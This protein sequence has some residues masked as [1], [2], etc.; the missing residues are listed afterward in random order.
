MQSKKGAR[1]HVIKYFILMYKQGSWTKFVLAFLDFLVLDFER[2]W[3][4]FDV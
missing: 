3:M 4:F 2:T 1:H